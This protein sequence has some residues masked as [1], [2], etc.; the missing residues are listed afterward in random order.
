MN[1]KK[2]IRTKIEK[3]LRKM[4][5]KKYMSFYE[6]QRIKVLSSMVSS[7]IFSGRTELQQMA[8]AN[9]ES[10]QHSSKVKQ[11]KRLVI[12]EKVDLETYFFPYIIPLLECLSASGE[13]VFSIDGSVAGRG[14]MC[15]MFS[16]IYKGKAIPVVW[17]VYKKK[18]GHLPEKEHRS[19]LEKLKKLVPEGC[20]VV[21][22]GDGE[23]DGCGWQ[24]DSLEAG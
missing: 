24:S 22:T 5:G 15:L 10:K 23:F 11:Y 21:I 12:N 1:D 13:L 17:D 19:L 6:L 16:V 3:S 4:L 9:P 2:F 18:K 8:L 7:I 14:C 20:R